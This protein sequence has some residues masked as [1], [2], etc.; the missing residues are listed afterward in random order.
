MALHTVQQ[1][2]SG[3]R[4][5]SGPVLIQCRLLQNLTFQVSGNEYMSVSVEYLGVATELLHVPSI[6]IDTMSCIYTYSE[7]CHVIHFALQPIQ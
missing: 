4:S 7:V 6:Q 2:T 3:L 1:C 5:I